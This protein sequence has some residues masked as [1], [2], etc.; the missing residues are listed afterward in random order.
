MQWYLFI[1]VKVV[2][3]H[4]FKRK[5]PRTSR[6]VDAVITVSRFMN[7]VYFPKPHVNRNCGWGGGSYVRH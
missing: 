5:F 3:H 7:V 1:L 2:R 6:I 4:S